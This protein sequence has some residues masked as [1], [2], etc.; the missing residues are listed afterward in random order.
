MKTKFISAMAA[1]LALL[2]F[3]SCESSSKLA[4]DLQGSWSGAPEKLIDNEVAPSSYMPVLTFVKTDATKGDVT[5]TAAISMSDANGNTT[6]SASGQSTISG[7]WTA[8]DDDEIYLNLDPST[9]NVSVDPDGVVM[10]STGVLYGTP[11]VTTDSLKASM[12]PAI[13]TRMT[14]AI[15]HHMLNITKIDDIKIKNGIMTCEI[16]DKDLSFHAIE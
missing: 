10:S 4:N 15:Q 14:S 1:S 11:E 12:I 8:T 13:K 3:S 9:L 16:N 5:I 6:L 2:S 7:T